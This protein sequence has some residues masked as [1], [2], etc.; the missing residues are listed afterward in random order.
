MWQ[1]DP[2]RKQSVTWLYF[3]F[4]ILSNAIRSKTI[5]H[6]AAV[7]ANYITIVSKIS[8]SFPML[9]RNKHIDHVSLHVH[10]LLDS[11]ENMLN[12]GF[13]MATYTRQNMLQNGYL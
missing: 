3:V 12:F 1:I 9:S 2:G 7:D 8:S 11:R 5:I 6:T 13:M 4:T 10:K